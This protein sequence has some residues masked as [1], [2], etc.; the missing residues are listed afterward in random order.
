MNAFRS[1][2]WAIV[3]VVLASLLAVPAFASGPP[4]YANYPAPD[5]LGTSAGEPS[6]GVDWATGKVLYLAGLQTLQVSFDDAH[7]PA[8]AFWQDVSF[9]LT[10]LTTL[11]PILTTDPKT[12]RTFVAQL[13]GNTS[14]MAFSD[15]DGASWTPGFETGLT[16]GIDHQ[17]V[18][19]GSFAS[20]LLGNLGLSQH[21]VYYC[22]QS[23]A[24]A[25]CAVSLNGGLTF[26]PAVPIYTLL[27]CDGLHGHV[28]VAPDGTAYVPNKSCNGAQGVAV[29]TNNGLTWTVRTVPGSAAA[30]GSDP[31]VGIGA[32][33]TVY[34]G[35]ADADGHARIAVSHNR[36]VTWSA[37]Q[38]VG[39]PFGIQNTAFPAVVAGDRDRAAYAFLGTPTPGED[40]IGDVPS[41]PGVWH[42]YI[43]T[44]TNGG[45]SWTTVDATP[46]D[47]VQR[48]SICLAGTT[49]GATRNLLDFLD[50]TVDAQGRVLVGY[51]DGCTGSCA[52]SGPN[53]GAALA[54]IARQTG[55]PRLF[56]AFDTP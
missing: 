29:S 21:A 28:K 4:T 56:A 5:P 1:R 22:S 48:G 6:I 36:G 20:G 25:A 18:G 33:G 35:Y 39:A 37:P 47:P 51:A 49:C 14:L 23:I 31:S 50:A 26:N 2:G 55:G 7:A 9:L 40:G 27:Q 15:N 54:T 41:F 45:G 34:F 30:P 44:T 43:A 42:L 13:A 17:T 24:Y 8:T 46:T 11:D 19:A 3:A 38:D 10:S 32:D 12:G 52:T 16:S 53:T